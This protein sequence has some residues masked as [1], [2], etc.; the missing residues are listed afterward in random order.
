MPARG[1]GSCGLGARRSLCGLGE[2][3]SRLC[4]NSPC[5]EDMGVIKPLA[6]FV[7]SLFSSLLALAQSPRPRSLPAVLVL[8]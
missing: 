8:V 5:N 4:F 1:R 3:T 6:L 2:A 7:F